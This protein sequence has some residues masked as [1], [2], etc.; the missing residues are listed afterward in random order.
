MKKIIEMIKKNYVISAGVLLLICLF[1]GVTIFIINKGTRALDEGV[2]NSVALRCPEK[3]AIDGEAKCEVIANIVDKTVMSVN[4][5]YNLPEGVTVSEFTVNTE[6]AEGDCFEEFA[7]TENGFAMANLNGINKSTSLGTL[8]LKF[9]TPVVSNKTYDIEFVN[10]EYSVE[11]GSGEY[12]MLSLENTKAQVRTLSDVN[13]LDS[14]EIN[15]T[16]DKEFSSD[17]LEYKVTVEKD[18]DKIKINAKA[19]DENAKIS[20]D[21]EETSLHYGTNSLKI[22]VTSE[23]GKEKTYTFNVYRKYEFNTDS[24][25]YNKDKNVLFTGSVYDNDKII[26]GLKLDD[27]LNKKINNGKLEVMYGE[28]VISTVDLAN[29]KY[30]NTV[31]NKMLYIDKDTTYE[32]LVNNL[33][34]NKVSI[35]VIDSSKQE[36]NSGVINDSM[37]MEV[38]YEDALLDTY[39]FT[40]SYLK[41]DDS[42]NV[43][44]EKKFFE[45][46]TAGTKI[47]ELKS[48]ISTSGEVNYISN[49]G[50]A[51]EDNDI[52]KTGDR[53][54]ININGTKTEYK[55]IVFGDVTGDGEIRSN[56]VAK[57]YRFIRGRISSDVFD[58]LCVSAGE[59]TG[60]GEIRS[61]DVA[62]IYRFIRGRISSL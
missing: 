59:V 62:K 30:T 51:V 41:L 50:N 4:A 19:S 35:K 32:T 27:S 61:N 21:T 54:S 5:N 29:F 7:N 17:V 12:E 33:T 18:V 45:K 48:K 26:A 9:S 2:T 22:I 40:A 60:D 1:V 37:K 52:I 10:V 6:C 8:T 56:D 53:V 13:T 44:E 39:T 38:Y 31:S 14:V 43:N 42:L 55:V 46:Q 58:D 49:D 34:L 16:F 3:V 24:Y 25:I 23:D 28:E 15:G 20:G 47:G 36:V 11:A 57:V